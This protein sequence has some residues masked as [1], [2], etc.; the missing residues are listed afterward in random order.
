MEYV[1]YQRAKRAALGLS[2]I[3]VALGSSAASGDGT[4]LAIRDIDGIAASP[5]SCVASLDG[6][7]C[8]VV[9]TDG[10]LWTNVLSGRN[11]S[12]KN[13]IGRWGTWRSMGGSFETRRPSCVNYFENI[14][15]YAVGKDQALWNISLVRSDGVYV[16]WPEFHKEAEGAIGGPSCALRPASRPGWRDINVYCATRTRGNDLLITAKGQGLI[17]VWKFVPDVNPGSYEH[18]AAISDPTC[19]FA[20]PASQVFVC[21]AAR[22]YSSGLRGELGLIARNYSPDAPT[23]HMT[24]PIWGSFSQSSYAPAVK[25]SCSTFLNEAGD[26]SVRC[27]SQDSDVTQTLE[28]GVTKEGRFSTVSTRMVSVNVNDIISSPVCQTMNGIEYQC[29]AT[30]RNGVQRTGSFV[31]GELGNAVGALKLTLPFK[32]VGSFKAVVEA[33]SCVTHGLARD[34]VSRRDGSLAMTHVGW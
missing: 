24:S 10:A 21:A 6:I 14:E 20:G 30:N 27:F 5:P 26:R 22:I 11:S 2:L 7:M 3:L 34:C 15:C 9:G 28:A 1:F 31:M 12:I 18:V 23:V 25:P 4:P 33:T 13:D 29:I 32:P 19:E 16:D 8:A 17:D